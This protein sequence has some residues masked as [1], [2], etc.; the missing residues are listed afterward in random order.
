M[1]DSRMYDSSLVRAFWLVWPHSFGQ[2]IGKDIGIIQEAGRF[3]VSGGAVGCGRAFEEIMNGI[4]SFFKGQ[5]NLFCRSTGQKFGLRA[6]E[7]N[8]LDSGLAAAFEEEVRGEPEVFTATK[9]RF[10]AE[11]PEAADFQEFYE[12]GMERFLHNSEDARSKDQALRA[13]ARVVLLAHHYQA[14]R[15][16]WLEAAAFARKLSDI[17]DLTSGGWAYR[18]TRKDVY[19]SLKVTVDECARPNAD[20]IAAAIQNEFSLRRVA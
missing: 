3:A 19:H 16:G 18:L 1:S 7:L 20:T 15:D 10:F 9:S 12:S 2:D 5:R 14:S 8:H 4:N 13:G 17:V 11:C 6:R